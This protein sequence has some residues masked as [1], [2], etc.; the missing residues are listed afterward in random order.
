MV[1]VTGLPGATRSLRS[2]ALR[3]AF[4]STFV[5]T[6]PGRTPASRAGEAT[7]PPGSDRPT[8]TTPRVVMATPTDWPPGTSV[9]AL[10]T[11]TATFLTGNTPISRNVTVASPA[12]SPVRLTVVTSSSV[13]FNPESTLCA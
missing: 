3:S 4:P 12:S 9:R 11:D 7:V 1:S 5:T 2:A 13:S 10:S 8:T 6:S